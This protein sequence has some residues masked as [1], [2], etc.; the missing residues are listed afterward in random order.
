MT[1]KEK[2]VE[3]FGEETVKDLI[4]AIKPVRI[5]NVAV[6]ATSSVAYMRLLEWLLDEYKEP[7]AKEIITA[8]NE[9]GKPIAGRYPWGDKKDT[10]TIY[11]EEYDKEIEVPTRWTVVEILDFYHSDK[12]FWTIKSGQAIRQDPDRYSYNEKIQSTLQ[13]MRYDFSTAVADLEL[14][15]EISVHMSQAKGGIVLQKEKK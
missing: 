10:M 4:S 7:A 15:K 6:P 9:E 2:M 8:V 13:K 12:Q 14:Q 3:V 5:P 1:K 11:S